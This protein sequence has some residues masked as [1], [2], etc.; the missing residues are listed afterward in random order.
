MKKYM[1]KKRNTLC[2]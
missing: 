2:K 1:Q